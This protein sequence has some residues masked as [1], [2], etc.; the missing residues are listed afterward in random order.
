[1]S[2]DKSRQQN[3]DGKKINEITVFEGLAIPWANLNSDKAMISRGIIEDDP[4]SDINWR[5]LYGILSKPDF[6]RA[7]YLLEFRKVEYG[8]INS[9]FDVTID[10]FV[11]IL[12]NVSFMFSRWSKYQVTDLC[13]WK[14][15]KWIELSGFIQYLGTLKWHQV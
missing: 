9:R 11:F 1:M 3:H 15:W 4:L 7:P 5:K 12:L 10:F 2:I 13:V 6:Q 14:S 8:I